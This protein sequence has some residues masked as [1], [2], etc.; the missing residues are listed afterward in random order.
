MDSGIFHDQAY[1]FHNR[2]ED[3]PGTNPE[4]LVAAAH[5]G[6]YAMALSGGL[7][8]AG[9]V[10]ER[11]DATATV[12]LDTVDGKPTVTK[13]HIDVTVKASGGDA[14]QIVNVAEATKSGCPISRLLNAEITIDVRVEA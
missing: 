9:L 1:S 10:P 12:T 14:A 2:F 3:V 13:S 5:A 4:E 6:C 8:G 7:A 11:I